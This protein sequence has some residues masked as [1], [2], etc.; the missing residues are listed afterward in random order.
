[1]QLVTDLD[2]TK[3]ELEIIQE[4]LKEQMVLKIEEQAEFEKLIAIKKARIAQLKAEEGLGVIYILADGRIQDGQ[5]NYL[6]FWNKSE[7]SINEV[8][9]PVT[10]QDEVFK[11]V[12]H[13]KGI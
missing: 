2:I 7:L 1:M 8:T 3:R 5:N 12:A 4:N 10:E 11:L 13:I 9:I 6:G